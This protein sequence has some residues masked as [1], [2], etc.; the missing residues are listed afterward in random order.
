MRKYDIFN[1]QY[2]FSPQTK[3]FV[4]MINDLDVNTPHLWKFFDDI[5]ASEVVPK[6][7]TSK[8]QSIVNQVIEWS[9][10]NREQLNPD[11]CKEL[12]ISFSRSPVELDAVVIDRK[13]VDVVST[14]KL[15][16]LITNADLNW[17]AHVENVAWK[18]IKRLHFLVQLKRTKLSPTDL[19]LYYNTC[20]RSVVDYA[21]QVL[22]NALPQYP[23]NALVRIEKRA[24]S[25]ILPSTSYNY[26][27]ETLGI[28]PMVDHI[29]SLCDKLFHSI[30]SDKDH[31]LNRLLP[32]L[33]KNPRV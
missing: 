19:I 32:P 9:H 10:I 13:E 5:T 15:L 26:A 24:I 3:F 23:I 31:T 4:L 21:V 6:G 7:N 18:A 25:I 28:T 17:N 33:H 14:A 11:N 20:V 2:F 30:A 1:C 12:Q 29:D 27:C 16:G 22:Y 8:A